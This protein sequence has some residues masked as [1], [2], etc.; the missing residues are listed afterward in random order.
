MW[1]YYCII[2]MLRT[3]RIMVILARYPQEK[4]IIHHLQS[5]N[6]FNQLLPKCN[7]R[8]KKPKRPLHSEN[9]PITPEN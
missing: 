1:N 6:A 5:I 8:N 2:I 3:L 7:D 4:L 9:W